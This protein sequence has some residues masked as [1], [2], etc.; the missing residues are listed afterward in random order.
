MY[1]EFQHD[2][3]IAAAHLTSLEFTFDSYIVQNKPVFVLLAVEN[4]TVHILKV[5]GYVLTHF[6]CMIIGISI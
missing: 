3:R 2:S 6:I 4:Y 5:I 1:M